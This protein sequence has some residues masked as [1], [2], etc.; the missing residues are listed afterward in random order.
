MCTLNLLYG[1]LY[2]VNRF[3]DLRWQSGSLL[4]HFWIWCKR[5]QWPFP[6]K[7]SGLILRVKSHSAA[8]NFTKNSNLTYS[9][10]QGSRISCLVLTD[11][12]A[13]AYWYT[14]SFHFSYTTISNVCSQLL[15]ASTN[16]NMLLWRGSEK[17]SNEWNVFPS[18]AWATLWLL[19]GL[20]C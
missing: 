8:Y 16:F 6:I 7:E 2:R 19:S 17:E 15:L 9:I 18:A 3:A 1:R 4:A 13:F 11:F 5:H 12:A 10:K 14:S 20:F